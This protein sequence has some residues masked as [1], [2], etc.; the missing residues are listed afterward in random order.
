MAVLDLPTTASPKTAG[1]GNQRRSEPL[2]IA[3]LRVRPLD[4][5]TD[6]ERLL[7]MCPRVSEQSRYQRFF[8]GLQRLSAPLLALLLDVDHAGREALVAL[9]GDAIIA[10]ARSA[11]GASHPTSADVSL[12]V[13]E[14]LQRRGIA[15]ELLTRLESS[16]RQQGIRV[17]SASVLGENR[18]ARGLLLAMHPEAR[19]RFERGVY[20]YRY[21]IGAA[22]ARTPSPRVARPHRRLTESGVC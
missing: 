3:G 12:L 7:D 13:V 11:V 6:G 21:E 19:G 9:D 2:G 20:A 15:R 16:A 4:P 1:R 10:V 18:Q 8:N 5:G 14:D 22:A 17:F